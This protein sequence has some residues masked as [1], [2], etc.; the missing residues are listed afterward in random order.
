MKPFKTGFTFE[1]F[2]KMQNKTVTDERITEIKK[3]GNAKCWSRIWN[4]WKCHALLARIKID[5]AIL[6][7]LGIDC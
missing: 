3:P 1:S 4:K 2:E 7:N 6:Q 5:K